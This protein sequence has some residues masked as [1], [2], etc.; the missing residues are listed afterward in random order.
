MEKQTMSSIEIPAS[1]LSSHH[2]NA[3]LSSERC[4]GGHEREPF[5][6]MKIFIVDDS[7][8]VRERL[9]SMLSDLDGASVIGSAQETGQAMGAIKELKPDVLIL[10]LN[11]PGGG[12]IK[13]L[14]YT[15]QETPETRIIIL[16]N[17]DYP[18]YRKKCLEAGADVFMD[19]LTEFDQV[20]SLVTQWMTHSV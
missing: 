2:E 20:P 5:Q 11:L 8:I 6:S 15:K 12:G 17:Y 18:Q 10:D 4:T 19:K 16:T 14:E 7:M 13:V 3:M 1:V 9:I